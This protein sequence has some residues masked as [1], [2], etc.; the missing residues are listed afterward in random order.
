M[1][2]LGIFTAGVAHEIR[3]PLASL[4]FRLFS[5]KQSLPPDFNSG[6]DLAVVDE[7]INRLERIIKDFLQFARP[8]LL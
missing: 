4:K 3:N 7:E 2:S 1:A 6:D 5:L 8:S